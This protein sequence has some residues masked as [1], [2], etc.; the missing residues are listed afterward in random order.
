MLSKKGFNGREAHTGPTGT[1]V[2]QPV[3]CYLWVLDTGDTEVS[4]CGKSF[5][6]NSRYVSRQSIF[7]CVSN[8]YDA[9]INQ[10]C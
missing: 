2:S 1:G 9:V 3:N 5:L 8:D 10:G 6:D 4:L 7:A